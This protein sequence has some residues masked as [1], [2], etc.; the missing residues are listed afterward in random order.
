MK[1]RKYPQLQLESCWIITNIAFGSSTQCESIV[2]KQGVE[3]LLQLVYDNNGSILE[4]AM[5]GLGN[6][7][8]DCNFC[9]DTVI[10]KG[11]VECINRVVL[12]SNSTAVIQLGCWV[13]SNICR[14]ETP[15]KY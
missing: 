9:R 8:G 1:D 5:W 2:S 12:N 15:P 14:G 13:L 7:A 3:A 4:Q 10:M 6:I 11:G